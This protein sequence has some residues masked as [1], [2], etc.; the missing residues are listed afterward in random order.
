MPDSGKIPFV[1]LAIAL[2]ITMIQIANFFN[3][4][5]VRANLSADWTLLYAQPWRVITSPFIHHDL[6]HYLNNLV[7]LCLFGWQI[8]PVYGRI[9]TLGIFL[10]GMVTGHVMS[11]TLAHDWVVGISNGVCGLFGFSLIANR[12]TPWWTTLTHR[13]LHAIYLANLIAPLIPFVANLIG[14]RVAHLTHLGGILYGMAFGGAFLLAPRGVGWREIVIAL[15]FVL[16]ASQFYS[17]WQIEWQLVKRPPTLLTA[18]ADCRLKS[19]EQKVLVPARINFVNM[20]TK[21]VALYWLDYDGNAKYYFLLRPGDSQEQ[22]SFIG[23]PWCIVDVDS[24]EALQAVITS[25]PNQTVTVR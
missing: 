24:G 2:I 18:S 5:A 23:H 16:V 17:P 10:G 13:P 1:T 22:D 21:K 3:P 7:F 12:R 4:N 19:L 9:K 6:P 8:E 15:P 25:E 11:I 20:S 14:F